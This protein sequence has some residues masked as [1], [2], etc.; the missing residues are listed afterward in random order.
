MISARNPSAPRGGAWCL[1]AGL[2]ALLALGVATRYLSPAVLLDIGSLW[3][4]GA[5]LLG[6]GWVVKRFRGDSRLAEVPL[7][8]L[9]LFSWMLVSTA[10]YLADLPGLPSS[11]A[12]L[13]GPP[14]DQ[15]GFDTFS[16]ALVDGRLLVSAES[17]P[18]AYRVDMIRGGGGAGV[19]VAVESQGAEGG[20]VRVIDARRPLPG[21]L[22]IEVRDNA[23]LRFA[24]WEVFLHPRTA[25]RLTLSAP[26]ISADLR[27]IPIASLVVHGEGDLRLGE[28]PGPVQVALHGTFSVE[29]PP[30]AAV[31]VAGA[32]IVPEEWTVEE[33]IAWVGESDAGWRIE[34]SEGE[35]VQVTTGTG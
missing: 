33:D 16:V 11:S 30:G 7:F 10:F 27:D 24:G 35:S 13:R 2:L 6:A 20:E 1:N 12:D 14:A 28:A 32:A 5:G 34:V 19:P 25:W 21:D 23:W 15:A 3:P 8:G 17:G 29:A 9:L 31:S 26:R 18:A 22:D 4:V